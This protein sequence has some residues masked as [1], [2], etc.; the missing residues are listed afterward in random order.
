MLNF[1]QIAERNQQE[2]DDGVRSRIEC[3][4]EPGTRVLDVGAGTSRYR[5]ALARHTSIAHDFGEYEGV[6]LDGTTQDAKLPM[7]QFSIGHHAVLEKPSLA[8]QVRE[9]LPVAA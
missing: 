5:Q 1:G 7:P 3:H 6:K 4:F 9:P 8:D 2:R